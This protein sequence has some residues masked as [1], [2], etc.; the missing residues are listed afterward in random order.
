VRR[1]TGILGQKDIAFRE[2]EMYNCNTTPLYILMF[3]SLSLYN[4]SPFSVTVTLIDDS[5]LIAN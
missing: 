2:K 3:G 1:K 5:E 4:I